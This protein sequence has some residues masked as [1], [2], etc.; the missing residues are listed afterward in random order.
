MKNI[1]E[2][3]EHEHQEI[4]KVV[5]VMS[6]LARDIEAG[7]EFNLSLLG[8]IVQFMR[9][10]GE[11]CHHVKEEKALFSLLEAKGVPAN[12]CPIGV[13]T[14]EHRHSHAL[15]NQLEMASASYRY[16]DVNARLVLLDLLKSLTELYQHHIWKEEY[17]L[18]PMAKKVLGATDYE[19]L[20]AQFG[21]IESSIGVDVHHG[22]EALVGVMEQ[23]EHESEDDA[24]AVPECSV[25]GAE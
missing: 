9:I 20:S 23:Q 7:Q 21:A 15:L 10:F 6:R 24:V 1:I 25:C 18:F 2:L 14:S 12:G 16:G 5:E 8:D 13:L 17:L 11:R 3:L 22:M 4:R 19:T